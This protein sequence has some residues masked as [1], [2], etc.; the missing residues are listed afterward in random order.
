ML[1]GITLN[2]EHKL[3]QQSDLVNGLQGALAALNHLD[4]RMSELK[5]DG[6]RAA[7]G[8][9]VLSDVADDVQAT[10]DAMDEVVAA[11]LP[12][13]L[14]QQFAG[15]QPHITGFSDFIAAFV[16]DGVANAPSVRDRIGEIDEGN[17]EAGGELDGLVD[18]V[19]KVI[20]Q[21]Q[22]DMNNTV[23]NTRMVTLLVAGVCMAGLIGLAVPTARSILGPVHRL[24]EVID[25]LA[26]GDLTS[27][28]GS[29]PRPP[30]R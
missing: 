15:Y 30:A 25:R 2:S 5:V 16:Q 29:R 13:D 1:V 8:H 6:Y 12:A 11:G 23:S 3:N 10:A 24:G 4:T 7:L 19:A 14:E 21:E 28:S 27:R 26:H 20:A 22:I 9:D 18:E 17:T